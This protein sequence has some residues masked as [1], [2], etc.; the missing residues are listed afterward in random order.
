MDF[1]KVKTFVEVVDCGGITLAANRL[2]RTQQAI[3]LQ[4]K[5][6]EDDIEFNLFYRQ[7]PKITLTE[8]GERLYQQFK[9]Q[10][11][12]MENAVLELRSEK[13][14]VSGLIRIAAWM[15]QAVS[16]LPEMMRIFKQQYPLVEFHLSIADDT[17]IELLLTN[18]KIDIGLQLYC[19]DK[20]VF[21]CES[22]YHQPLIPVISRKFLVDHKAPKTI[23]DTLDIPLLDYSNEYS[24]YN[25]WISKNAR[26][27]LPQARKKIRAV[28]TSN[29]VVLKQLVLQGLGFGFL[30]QEAIQ[31]ELAIGELVPLITK[32]SI[33]NIQVDIDV[34]YKRKHAL[35]YVHLA[36]IKLLLENRK[37]WTA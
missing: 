35:G 11:L 16:Y 17:E 20:K 2:L 7:G 5:Q 36:F 26:D 8:D 32:S 13:Q 3:S 23:K 21:K 28:T 15:E 29:N 1:N 22:V 30:H 18:N 33:E 12:A 19:Q 27:L 10:L 34:V 37:S 14:Q 9:P 25:N 24:A 31:S 6:L 4:L